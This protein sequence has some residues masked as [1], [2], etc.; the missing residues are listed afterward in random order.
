MTASDFVRQTYSTQLNPE[1]RAQLKEK[2]NGVDVD[3]SGYISATELQM[4]FST[5]KAVFPIM[6]AKM[7]VRIYSTQGQVSYEEV[8]NLD[9]FVAKCVEAFSSLATEGRQ[10]PGAEL[11]KAFAAIYLR[12]TQQTVDALMQHFDK[13]RTGSLSLQDFLSL[14]GICLL[15]RTLFAEWDTQDKGELVVGIEQV[16]TI[17]LWFI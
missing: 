17:G 14:C 6:A 10:L 13:G 1:R 3:G 11:G 5:P 4:I 8:V 15:G 16:L 12:F 2:F 9:A 7:L